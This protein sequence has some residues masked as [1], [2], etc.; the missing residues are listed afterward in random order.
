[1][2]VETFSTPKDPNLYCWFPLALN[3]Y[4]LSRNYNC[5]LK[6]KATLNHPSIINLFLN[7]HFPPRYIS[8]K[9]PSRNFF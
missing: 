3:H 5:M 1:M 6:V 7:L 8:L 4:M 2:D 9:I